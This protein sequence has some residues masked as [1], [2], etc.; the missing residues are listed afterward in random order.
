MKGFFSIDTSSYNNL[1]VGSRAEIQC[2]NVSGVMYTWRGPTNEIFSDP[3]IISSVSVSNDES[4]YKCIANISSNPVNCQTQEQSITLDV[5]SKY[6]L[7]NCIIPIS[8][9]IYNLYRKHCIF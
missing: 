4:T 8:V 7:V 5:I 2:G 9:Y 1:M 6:E 3:L